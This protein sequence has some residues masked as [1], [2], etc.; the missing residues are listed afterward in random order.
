MR[1][2]EPRLRLRPEPSQ[3]ATSL[4]RPELRCR[5]SGPSALGRTT[6][7]PCRAASSVESQFQTLPEVFL[8]FAKLLPQALVADGNY[9]GSED[10]CVNGP[11][12]RNGG[13]RHS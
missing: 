4:R 5:A 2:R 13:D 12:D 7:P 1:A 10:G 9:L 6:P 3:F 11:I 8:E